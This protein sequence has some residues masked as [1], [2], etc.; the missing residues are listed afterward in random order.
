MVFL[1]TLRLFPQIPLT[2]QLNRKTLSRASSQSFQAFGSNPTFLLCRSILEHDIQS[3]HSQ[4]T[5]IT[6]ELRNF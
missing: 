2:D 3:R 4:K 6:Q 1:Q 5:A